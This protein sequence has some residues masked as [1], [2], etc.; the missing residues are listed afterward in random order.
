MAEYF[1]DAVLEIVDPNVLK[2]VIDELDG[3]GI[4]QA[5]AG[6]EG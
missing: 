1:R 3:F 4:P 2:Q 5:R 6:C